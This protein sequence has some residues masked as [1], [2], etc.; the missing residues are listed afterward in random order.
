MCR[1]RHADSRP[2]DRLS[3]RSPA[4]VIDPFGRRV[5]PAD[6]VE[7]RRLS[8]ARRAHQREEIP[9]GDV[10]RDALQHVDP[11]PARAGRSCEGREPPPK[12]ST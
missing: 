4:I 6:Q 11:L 3:M 9:L 8:R 7:E 5:E 1:A 2:P 10:E 12:S